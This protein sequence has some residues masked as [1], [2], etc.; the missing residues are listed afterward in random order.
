MRLLADTHVLLWAIDAPDRLSE[1]A[2][3]ALIDDNNV[4][5]FSVVSLWEIAI[6]ISLGRLELATDWL[7]MIED[8]RNALGARW[9][10]LEPRHCDQVASLPWHHRDPFD[11]MLAAQAVCEGLT[12]VSRDRLLPSYP[13]PVLW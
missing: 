7:A 13:V 1:P 4:I 9:M 6:K 2:R 11:R 10:Q 5:S 12:L 3:R 8:G